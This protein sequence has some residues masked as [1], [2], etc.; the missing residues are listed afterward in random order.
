MLNADDSFGPKHVVIIAINY[1]HKTPELWS[2]DCLCTFALKYLTP[3]SSLAVVGLSNIW[4]A[5]NFS[6]QFCMYLASTLELPSQ[7]YI[8]LE[9]T[10]LAQVVV[11]CS[12]LWQW[13]IPYSVLWHG[14][15]PCSVL[16]H[17]PLLMACCDM[18]PF[19]VACYDMGSFLIACCDS[20]PFL[21][22]CCDMGPFLVACC[23]MGPFLIPE[24]RDSTFLRNVF[25][26][27]QDCTVSKF[28]RLQP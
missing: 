25:I 22:A 16:W 2:S 8:L 28:K 14:T 24:Y 9:C 7:C 21:V 1:N 17:L 19:L 26:S 10:N 12:V 23:D 3:V 13:A 20:G 27:L 6:I 11:T 5:F 18:G 4:P 15:I